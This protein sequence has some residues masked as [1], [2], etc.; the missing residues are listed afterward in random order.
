MWTPCWWY[1]EPSGKVAV[2]VH[3]MMTVVAQGQP[4][5]HMSVMVR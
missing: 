1:G 5:T 2:P 3:R 4:L